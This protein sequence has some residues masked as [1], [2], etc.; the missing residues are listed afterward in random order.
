M[1]IFDGYLENEELRLQHEIKTEKEY[2]YMIDSE[3]NDEMKKFDKEIDYMLFEKEFNISMEEEFLRI[4][5]EYEDL[6]ENSRELEKSMLRIK[7]EFEKSNIEKEVQYSDQAYIS[8]PLTEEEFNQEMY[9]EYLDML[10][11]EEE[12]E[13]IMEENEAFCKYLEEIEEE[14]EEMLLELND[15]MNE[16]MNEEILKEEEEIIEY[17]ERTDQEASEYLK[18]EIYNEDK[19]YY[20]LLQKFI[21]EDF[22]EY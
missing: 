5:R 1:K 22:F 19:L 17:M 8:T 18:R 7:E 16:K 20:K 11:S 4:M 12:N 2:L 15:E 10:Y 3:E 6:K 13:R 14:I 21:D 9:S